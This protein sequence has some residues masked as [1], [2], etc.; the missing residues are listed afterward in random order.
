[1][2][3][4]RPTAECRRLSF[5]GRIAKTGNCLGHYA[6]LRYKEQECPY[7]TRMHQAVQANAQLVGRRMG[8]SLSMN[9]FVSNRTHIHL[10]NLY[11]QTSPSSSMPV[12]KCKAAKDGREMRR[13]GEGQSPVNGNLCNSE[14]HQRHP[15]CHTQLT[16]RGRGFGC[17]RKENDESF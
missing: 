9:A 17:S 12:E 16:G 14:R 8:M 15:G 6:S 13:K 2:T 11:A 5:D 1:M 10:L 3:W 7:Q 4:L